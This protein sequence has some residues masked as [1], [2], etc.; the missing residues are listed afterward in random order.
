MLIQIEPNHGYSINRHGG[1]LSHNVFLAMRDL[2]STVLKKKKKKVFADSNF[3]LICSV[4][5]NTEL[6]LG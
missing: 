1:A 5:I 4:T 6:F 2:F 3:Y